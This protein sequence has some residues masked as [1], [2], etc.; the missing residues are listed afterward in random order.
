LY[1]EW[2][3]FIFLGAVN[4]IGNQLFFL[5]ALQFSSATDGALFQ[6]VA[7]IVTM[8]IALALKR[9][10]RSVIFVLLMRAVH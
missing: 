1:P 9:E 7:P 8:C 2:K 6:P 3:A 5:I 4:Q 10:P